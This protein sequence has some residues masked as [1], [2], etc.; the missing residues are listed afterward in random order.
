MKKI[1]ILLL[2]LSG[3]LLS[4]AQANGINDYRPPSQNMMVYKTLPRSIEELDIQKMFIDQEW[5]PGVVKFKSNRPDMQVPIIFDI[6]SNILYYR[7]GSVIMEFVDSVSQFSMQI[8]FENDSATLIFKR[9]YPA[10]QSNSPETFYQVLVPGKIQ[11]LKCRAK[12][13]YLFKEPALADNRKKEPK[14]LYFAYLP[15]DKMVLLRKDEDE[16]ITRMPDYA[17]SIKKIIKEYH[18]KLKNEEKLV[19]L[20]THLNDE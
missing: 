1:L 10:F 19:A 8:P 16:L 17:A 12:S 5:M 13:I 15:G 11:L 14:A 9:F 6:Y 7:Q 3:N 4:N 18:I 20:F 2:L